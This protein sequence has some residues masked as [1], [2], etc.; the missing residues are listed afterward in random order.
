MI[1]F[2]LMVGFLVLSNGSS[3][4][5]SWYDYECCSQR[6]CRAVS[7]EEVLELSEGKWKYL[8]LAVVFERNMVKNSKDSRFHVCISPLNT[9]LCIYILSGV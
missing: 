9:P 3:R 1:K 5:H 8:P 7:S 6:D 4:A 2:L